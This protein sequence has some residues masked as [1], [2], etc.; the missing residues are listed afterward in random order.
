MP[1]KR[2]TAKLQ[3]ANSVYNLPSIKQVVKWMHAVCSYPMKSTWLKAIKAGNF[4]GWPLLNE[5]NVNKYYPDTA[6]TPKGHM[7]QKRKNLYSTKR[8]PFEICN[9]A[10]HLRGKKEQ[11]VFMKTYNVRETIFSDQ[12]GQYPTTSQRGNKYIMVLVEIDS[13]T[14]LV[15]PMK[16]QNDSKMIRAY[17]AIVQRLL[18]AGMQPKKHVLLDNKIS[19]NMKQHIKTK[20]KF[21]LEMVPPGCHLR[22][23][24]KLAIHNFKA[25]FLSVLA[26]TADNFPTNNLWDRLLPQTEITL[27]LL[28]QSNATPTVLGL[29]QNPISTNEL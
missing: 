6:K 1:R 19:D 25:H 12:T 9:A 10:F 13:N 24:A 26:G 8:Q 4:T 27:N 28:R 18:S 20:Y 21:N 14:I 3:Q 17:D 29:Q 15:E 16:S 23:A 5:R 11:D 22:N 2:V 7:N